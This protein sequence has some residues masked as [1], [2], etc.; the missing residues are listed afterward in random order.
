MNG[1]L[2]VLKPPGMT[3][4][5]VVV[6]VRRM[7]PKGTRVGHAGTLD[8]E[9][10]GV[11]PIMVGK[12]ARL[13]DYLVDK[14]K[15]YVA[16]LRLGVA[17]DT[18][19][20]QGQVCSRSAQRPDDGAIQAVLPRFVGEI[21]Q[22]PPAY[23]ALKQ[24]GKRLYALA[25]AGEAVDIPPRR[26]TV[27]GIALGKR[28]SPD[29]CLLTVRCGKGTYI[30]TLC[31]DLGQ[32]LGCGAHMG[33]L[34]RTQS[35]IFVLET[36]CTL[37][38]LEAAEGNLAPLLLAMDAPLAHLP[39]V[40]VLPSALR[41]CLNGNVL[42]PAQLVQ[43]MPVRKGP[44]R[45]YVGDLFAGIGRRNGEEVSFDAMLLERETHETATT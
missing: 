19:D 39:A 27:Y 30:R 41:T 45:I 36:A 24:N 5:D 9:A 34:L 14:E 44:L 40:H 15:T 33:F 43:P 2:N 6:R 28:I 29:E 22:T 4:S 23:S 32:A 8:P 17:T 11:L 1:F 10:A 37:A 12:A 3:S 20:A 18:Q 38:S 26:V 7:L 21:L 31:H 42:R 13:F 35:G 25:R 16:A